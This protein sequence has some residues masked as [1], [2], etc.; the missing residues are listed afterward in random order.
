MD[1][2]TKKKYFD[3]AKPAPSA[4]SVHL[5]NRQ[6]LKP[7]PEIAKKAS[8]EIE[9]A[10]DTLL[11]PANSNPPA[12]LPVS[13]PDLKIDKSASETTDEA[14]TSESTEENTDKTADKTEDIPAVDP[15]PGTVK[16]EVSE[17]EETPKDES[18]EEKPETEDENE[19]K[20][21]PADESK[22]AKDEPDT[23][24]PPKER[25]AATDALP[26]PGE[27]AAVEAKETMQD[28]KIF[29]T[30][31]YYVPIGNTHHGH[32]HLKAAL[33][34]GVI[35]AVVVIGAAIY[36]MSRLAK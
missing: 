15:L 5:Q 23:P 27:K 33:L 7:D 25:Y 28:P 36:I 1:S 18:T 6:T 20:T 22:D 26:D 31:E 9:A 10:S 34:F 35:C 16:E 14:A 12:A 4:P 8:K 17:K 11:D 13:H 2:D 29:D 19:P 32:G 21:E 3:V 30:K 24:A